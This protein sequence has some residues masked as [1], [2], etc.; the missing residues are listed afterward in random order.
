MIDD[1]E[2][3]ALEADTPTLA[4]IILPAYNTVD[5]TRQLLQTT[6]T[7]EDLRQNFGDV[8]STLTEL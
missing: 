3:A 1:K 4:P 8:L 5:L 6:R 7:N 2:A